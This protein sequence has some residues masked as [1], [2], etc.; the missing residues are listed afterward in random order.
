MHLTKED[1]LSVDQSGKYGYRQWATRIRQ[2]ASRIADPSH[3]LLHGVLKEQ[4]PASITSLLR[5]KPTSFDN[6]F[7]RMDRLDS[8]DVE[9]A[10]NQHRRAA[11]ATQ[12]LEEQG[13]TI[14]TLTRASP[15]VH[16][17]T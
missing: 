5:L 10:V 9:D 7:D 16:T 15:Q 3:I 13:Y 17:Q 11:F 12:F 1:A 2:A 14:P 6:A 8:A 4:L